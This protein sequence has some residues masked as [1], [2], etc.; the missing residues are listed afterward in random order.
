VRF[1]DSPD[2]LVIERAGR[3]LV[4]L[5]DSG[6]ETHEALVQT[7]FGPGVRLRD[8]SGSTDNEI[9]TDGDGMA[10]VRVPPSR[11]AVWGPAGVAGGIDRP[12]RRNTQVFE[13]ADDLGDAGTGAPGYGGSLVAGTYR[14]AGAVWVAKGSVVRV[15]LS[16]AAGGDAGPFDLRVLKPR[17]GGAKARDQGQYLRRG[18]AHNDR[19]LFLQFTADREGYY[20][21]TARRAAAAPGDSSGAAVHASLK[22]E[23]QA[24]A[25]SAK[26]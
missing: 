18:V 6:T 13:M 14:T 2:L 5:N 3:A 16:S 24:P 12:G 11:Y 20:Q 22:V 8:Y 23:Y 21:L 10:R 7:D 26:F 17:P 4:G 15:W 25:T 9:V 19:P 1:Q